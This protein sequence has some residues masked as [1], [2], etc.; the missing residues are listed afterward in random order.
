[1]LPITNLNS[2]LTFSPKKAILLADCFI[3][4]VKKGREGWGKI[5]K[6]PGKLLPRLQET[7]SRSADAPAQLSPRVNVMTEDFG[8]LW[9][10][11]WR[12][13]RRMTGC[14]ETSGQVRERRREMQ[15][16]VR[17]RTGAGSRKATSQGS[18]RHRASRS[19]VDHYGRIRA[20]SSTYE[21]AG[22]RHRGNNCQMITYRCVCR[23]NTL[24]SRANALPRAALMK[25]CWISSNVFSRSI[26]R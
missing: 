23:R 13:A 14:D 25:R 19:N 15:A 26:R 3:A 18:D 5:E 11:L 1:V 4:G 17:S 22:A 2:L 10:F 20:N 7:L 24:N 21:I 6:V 16:R 12:L 8:W 9:I